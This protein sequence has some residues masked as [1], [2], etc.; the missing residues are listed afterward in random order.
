[1]DGNSRKQ[2][3][4]REMRRRRRRAVRGSVRKKVKKLQRLVPGGRDLNPDHLLL[5][6]ADYILQLRRQVCV[7]QA[8]SQIYMP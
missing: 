2:M 3:C 1:M 8:L 4:R 7:L 6:T 5:R